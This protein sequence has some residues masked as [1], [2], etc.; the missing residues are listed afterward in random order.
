MLEDITITDGCGSAVVANGTYTVTANAA[1]Y[2]N[3]SITPSSVNITQGTDTYA[4]TIAANGTLTIHVT[5]EGTAG[6][7]PIASAAFVRT[8]KAGTQ[9]GPVIT[10]DASGNAIFENVPF[11]TGAPPVYFRQTASDGAHE[12][13][14][15]LQS[16]ALTTQTQTMEIQNSA[17]STRTINLTDSNYEKLP[18]ENAT[19]TLNN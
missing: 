19:L 15:T 1:G 8:D 5:E 11:G 4:F 2:D 7:T 10:S 3:T 18:I 9:Y 14:D 13:V 16:I 12:F 17:G 6:G